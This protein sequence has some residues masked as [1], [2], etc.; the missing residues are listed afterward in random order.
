M[1][2]FLENESVKTALHSFFNTPL[3]SLLII[4]PSGCGKTT[5]CTLALNQW[6]QNIQI[7]RP[8]YSDY[9]THKDFQDVVQRFIQTRN[10][11]EIFE[12]KTKLLFLDDVEILL[13]Q[14]RYA[15]SF[16]ST[17]L[18]KQNIKLLITCTST[19]EKR[20]SDI[21]KCVKCVE[22]LVNPS[23]NTLVNYFE[24]LHLNNDCNGIYRNIRSCLLN[25]QVSSNQDDSLYYLTYDKN[26]C[27]TVETIF[28]NRVNVKD[29]E[30]CIS[31]DPYLISYIL[32]ENFT[33]FVGKT[34]CI[35]TDVLAVVRGFAIASIFETYCYGKLEPTISDIGNLYRCGIIK[36]HTREKQTTNSSIV[37]TTITSRASN[38]YNTMKR[39]NEQLSQYGLSYE[40][41][42]RFHEIEP[43]TKS[44]KL[45]RKHKE[46]SAFNN[47]TKRICKN[48]PN[49]GKR[50]SY[51]VHS[52]NTE[53]DK[54]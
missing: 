51:V 17:L 43:K 18:A 20:L 54:H 40:A 22:H 47:Y 42:L 10:L 36:L 4:G 13:G 23:L 34:S 44:N 35:C 15:S 52:V 9:P 30:L 39:I 31:S 41:M 46:D 32:Y 53:I 1:N 8:D 6:G 48:Q 49:L 37:Y 3:N 29:L 21:R 45:Y 2:S 25:S 24:A 11:S 33:K 26:I 19:E 5:I 38:Y 12:K 50:Q 28:S 27:D 16:I 7:L 14:D